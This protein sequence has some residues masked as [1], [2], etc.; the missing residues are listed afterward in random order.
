MLGKIQVSR[1]GIRSYWCIPTSNTPDQTQQ[2]LI[3]TF[4]SLSMCFWGLQRVSRT[5]AENRWF[6]VWGQAS[7]GGLLQEAD[8]VDRKQLFFSK[9]DSTWGF[10]NIPNLSSNLKVTCRRGMFNDSKKTWG[11]L[12]MMNCD[13]A[14]YI[15]SDSL[16][17]CLMPG[18][19]SA[20]IIHS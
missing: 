11:N 12:S 19:D 7:A 18:H 8:P 10:S 2:L 14:F 13:R 5:G 17:E 20:L 4:K 1:I 9:M 16:M 15:P 3:K 6:T